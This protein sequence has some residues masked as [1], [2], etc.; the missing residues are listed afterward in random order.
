MEQRKIHRTKNAATEEAKK[1]S[2]QLVNKIFKHYNET[3]H[4]PLNSTDAF[5]NVSDMATITE[6]LCKIIQR[7]N[8]SYILADS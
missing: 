7:R 6:L 3:P 1:L 4:V 8:N 5:D 2:N